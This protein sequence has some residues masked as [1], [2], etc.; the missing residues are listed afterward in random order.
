MKEAT[1]ASLRVLE[2]FRAEIGNV[3]P[4]R[5]GRVQMNVR[6]TDVGDR[7]VNAAMISDGT[8]ISFHPDDLPV[9]E[10]LRRMGNPDSEG[11]ALMKGVL[12]VNGLQFAMAE[13]CFPRTGPVLSGPL[14]EKLKAVKSARSEE[15][16]MMG[17]AR[18]LRSGGI[19]VGA[20]DEAGWIRAV[21]QVRLTREQA[22]ALNE[23]R[24]KFLMESG[25]SGFAIKAAPVLLALERRCVM[26]MEGAPGGAAAPVVDSNVS[27]PQVSVE[28]ILAAFRQQNPG[29][30]EESITVYP[31]NGGKGVKVVSDSVV[32]L[33]AFAEGGLIQ[34]L[35]LE[36]VRAK[37]PGLDL[38]PLT[39]AGL[40]ELR[41]KGY[42]PLD[43]SAFRGMTLRHL[44]LQGVNVMSLVGLEGLP[45]VE[46]D[47]TASGV[48]ELSP[49][50]GMKL[51]SLN[52]NGTKVGSLIPLA[53]MPLKTLNGRGIPV[54]DVS[55]LRGLPLETLDLSETPLMDF[56]VLRGLNL[57]VLALAKTSLKDIGICSVM[58][59][60]SL[61]VGDTAITDISC[62]RGKNMR[63]LIL[64]RTAIK[65][66]APLAGS[67]IHTLDLSG[68]KTSF[69]M[70]PQVLSK[71]RFHEIALDNI[72]LTRIDFLRG[73][74]LRR[75]SL[76]GTKVTDLSPLA[77]M[78]IRLL[79][80]R[81]LRID[82]ASAIGTLNMLEDLW[83]D[84]DPLQE[85]VLLADLPS[86]RTI[87]GINR[88]DER[89][90]R[91]GRAGRPRPR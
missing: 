56:S 63:R 54:R 27:R 91:D 36:A 70:L 28:S 48:K 38:K 84:L 5:M 18:V 26:G 45:L 49:L 12:A 4:V 88:R 6:I 65:D 25:M 32:N 9:E 52:L 73:K 58:P 47:L 17:L 23:Q 57:R 14:M 44:T 3:V 37:D 31:S 46:L 29:V 41:I 86:L 68:T 35:W 15:E 1:T 53:G 77:N 11:A 67:S 34:G 76:A 50:H 64:A 16:V 85:R 89:F 81:G 21:E 7:K 40:K 66:I 10:R 90:E 71:V 20:Y 8:Q 19:A 60:E 79:N 69:I 82:D 51:E 55:V 13:E 33:S 61:D 30:Q 24:E 83:C 75:V 59:L 42:L 80:I 39:K 74:E 78:P 72:E 43:L 22:A 87:N 2:S 62:L